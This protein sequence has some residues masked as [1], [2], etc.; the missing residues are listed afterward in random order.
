M[1]SLFPYFFL[2]QLTCNYA[3]KHPFQ[4]LKPN[5][6]YRRFQKLLELE[7]LHFTYCFGL[8]HRCL[9][10]FIDRRKSLL[11]FGNFCNITICQARKLMYVIAFVRFHGIQ[12]CRIIFF[13]WNYFF[14]VVVS[15]DMFYK[16]VLSS[17]SNRDT[18]WYNR[19][20]PFWSA[21][22]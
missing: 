22:S 11:G 17:F 3:V 4:K 6:G 10:S 12:T 19:N 16:Y 13:C 14:S 5:L 9:D 2:V 20:A 15:I 8:G 21:L 1:H 18:L 7:F